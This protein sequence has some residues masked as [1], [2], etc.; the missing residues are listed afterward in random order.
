MPT[1]LK[2][3]IY[4]E[5]VGSAKIK[6]C[7]GVIAMVDAL[8]TR[9]YSLDECINF[10]EKRQELIQR[11]FQRWE[12]ASSHAKESKNN[13]KK[14]IHFLSFADTLIVAIE[15]LEFSSKSDKIKFPSGNLEAD[16]LFYGMWLERLSWVM[17]DL[18][19]DGLIE[20]IVFR[21][22]ISVGEY[23]FDRE[24]K[25]ILGPTMNDVANWYE[26]F[27]C[28][29]IILTPHASLII[30]YLAT[31]R[32]Y[33]DSIIKTEIPF[34]NNT[35]KEC[36]VVNWPNSFCRG[37]YSDENIKKATNTFLSSL[38]QLTI[39]SGAEDRYKVAQSFFNEVISNK[40]MNKKS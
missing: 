34:K 10:L 21:G 12:V 26:A 11:S 37:D 28:N 29:G 22:A 31:K 9:N 16:S 1:R 27:D 5:D 13:S 4:Y 14:K 2:K 33:F 19:R 6:K 25:S 36:Y 38:T 8:G 35:T 18:L 32:K 39:P 3:K 20:K 17:G 24:S 7:Y 40:K 23:L 15:M 30:E